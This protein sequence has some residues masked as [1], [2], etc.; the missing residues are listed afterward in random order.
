MLCND[1]LFPHA[2]ACD[3]NTGRRKKTETTNSDL[4]HFD[5]GHCANDLRLWSALFH[6]SKDFLN[7][8]PVRDTFFL[9]FFSVLYFTN[10]ITK[11]YSTAMCCSKDFLNK[12][13]VRDIFFLSAICSP[14]FFRLCK[15]STI[16]YFIVF[17]IVLYWRFGSWCRCLNYRSGFFQRAPA[18]F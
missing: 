17:V 16:V 6:C 10:Q 7:K 11:K 14:N 8:H 1:C 18:N 5:S 12:H 13:P 2:A 3:T 4:K 9:Q 15:G